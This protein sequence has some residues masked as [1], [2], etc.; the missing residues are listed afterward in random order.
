MRLGRRR[1]FSYLAAGSILA[2]AILIEAQSHPRQFD[3]PIPLYAPNSAWNQSVVNVSVLPQSDQQILIL[4]RV[5][6]GDT[7]T[8][9]PPGQPAPTTWPFMDVNY[10]DFSIAIF[11]TGEGQQAVRTTDYEGN[12][13][14]SHKLTP[15]ADGRLTVPAP[16]GTVRP[17]G[18]QDTDAD[19]HLVLYDS[20]QSLEYDYWQATTATDAD[21][22]SLGGGQPG[23][24][25]TAAGTVDFFDL[26]GT[27]ANTDTLWSARAMGTPLLAGLLLPE[28]V[29]R[30]VIDH[31][32]AFAVP[33]PRNTTGSNEAEP[34]P[35]DY[36]YPTSTTETDFFNTYLSALAA[37]QRIRLRT[38]LVDES[39]NTLDENQLA[40]ITRMFLAALRTYGA[41]L[42]NNAGGLTF[43]AE[44]A[45]TAV[46]TLDPRRD[47]VPGRTSRRYSVPRRQVG[48][49]S[50][51]GKA[52]SGSRA[53]SLCLWTLAGRAKSLSPA[54][55]T[56]ANFEVVEPATR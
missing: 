4:Y 15:G 48:L 50:R 45:H 34:V 10:D 44:D 11:A 33:G 35:G 40:P 21:G 49:A 24:R 39:G 16:A 38:S 1:A 28:D 26:R 31:A 36:F 55:V 46:L 22:V 54:T 32:L 2:P 17:S 56:R 43:Y 13:S 47:Q 14:S 30:G 20:N 6:R 18:P 52:Q 25:I 7:L 41:T 51:H 42:V 8:L 19:G 5:L 29:E 53:H 9:F 12:P 37:G 27:G 3:L 23:D